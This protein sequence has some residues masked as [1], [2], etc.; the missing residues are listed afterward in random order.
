MIP[1]DEVAARPPDGLQQAPVRP[2]GAWVVGGFLVFA[3]LTMWILV[4]VIFMHRS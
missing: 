4:S 2:V 1:H 3:V